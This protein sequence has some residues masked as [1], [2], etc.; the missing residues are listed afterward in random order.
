MPPK[1]KKAPRKA[2]MTKAARKQRVAK[3]A[4]AKPKKAAKKAPAKKTAA[5]KPAAR[6]APKAKQCVAQ[7]TKKYMER[8]GPNYP[9]QECAG[10]YAYGSAFGPDDGQLWHSTKV[11]AQTAFTWKKVYLTHAQVPNS[12]WV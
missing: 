11:G 3:K 5:K 10:K 7:F 8:P 2:L 12:Q 4:P 1:A 9:A 6:K